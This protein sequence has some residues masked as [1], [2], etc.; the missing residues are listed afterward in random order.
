MHMKDQKTSNIE[1]FKAL[2][3]MDSK[4]LQ[5]QKDIAERFSVHSDAG[6]RE[7]AGDLARAVLDELKRQRGG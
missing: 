7:A 3:G 1:E 5:R 2:K 6:L 4:Q